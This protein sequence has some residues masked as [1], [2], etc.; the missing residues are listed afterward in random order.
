VVEGVNEELVA[1]ITVTAILMLLASREFTRHGELFGSQCRSN[2][3][4]R[5]AMASIRSLGEL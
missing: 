1:L 5:L 2:G 4:V 3:P